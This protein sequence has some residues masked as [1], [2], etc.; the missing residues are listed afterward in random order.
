[1]FSVVTISFARIVSTLFT[2]DSPLQKQHWS[3]FARDQKGRSTD[4]TPH[5]ETIIK[6]MK[7]M[8]QGQARKTRYESLQI[9][10]QG[11]G[12]RI[13]VAIIGRLRN[14]VVMYHP[15]G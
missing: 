14:S 9:G 10:L 4:T 3:E 15:L 8:G 7:K 2:A 11:Q 6:I 1:M 12:R 13:D 5:D